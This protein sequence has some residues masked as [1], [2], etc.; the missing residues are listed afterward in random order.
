MQTPGGIHSGRPTCLGWARGPQR[1]TL[2][3]DE[4]CTDG[5]D[6]RRRAFGAAGRGL[7]GNCRER[8][9]RVEKQHDVYNHSHYCYKVVYTS[10]GRLIIRWTRK[11]LPFFLSSVSS[12]AASIVE[13]PDMN[14]HRGS[15]LVD[16]TLQCYAPE[17]SYAMVFSP[18]TTW[19]R[20]VL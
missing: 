8:R 20:P 19:N 16:E 9:R 17:V 6:T 2:G 1:G 10:L 13:L 15:V 7:L 5:K 3:A 4:P 14:N 11:A 12:S 18:V